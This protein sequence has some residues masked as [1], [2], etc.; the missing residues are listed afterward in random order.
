MVSTLNTVSA[1][2]YGATGVEV[3]YSYVH[4][5]SAYCS[6]SH[7]DGY[8]RHYN[9]TFINKCPNCGGKLHYEC[10]GYWVEGLWYCGN[11]DMDFC[12][13]HGKSHDTRGYYLTRTKLPE[14]EKEQ[15]TQDNK[16][17]TVKGPLGEKI[18]MT[19]TQVEQLKKYNIKI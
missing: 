14:P 9:I 6:C 11:C 8:Y 4:V 1:K 2:Y 12:L 18:T 16:N 19:Q 7:S 15:V 13:V 5:D 10:K 17:I 3:T